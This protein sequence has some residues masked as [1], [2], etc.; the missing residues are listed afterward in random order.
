MKLLVVEDDGELCAQVAATLEQ[1]GFVVD[2]AHDG[3]QGEFLGS[4]ERYAAVVLDLG[5]PGLGGVE[6]LQRWR[7][8]GHNQP[9]LILT[10]RDA[11]GDKVAAF[12]AGA[13][14]YL[15]KPFRLEELVLRLQVLIR[16]AAGHAGG[17][18]RAG[19]LALDTA[20]GVITLNGLALKLTAFESRLLRLLLL[21]KGRTV[22]RT[23]MV[24]QMYDG[25]ADR[26]F[27]SLEVV[28][29]RLRR[30]LGEGRIE[31]V[32]GEGYRLLDQEAA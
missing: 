5:L 6:V 3:T 18:V 8:A 23:D 25:D 13:D 9:V 14:D 30:K 4:T 21:H 1:A 29:G 16:R 24:E 2:R 26:D 31:T 10:A 17:E 27:R 19:P 12:K 32:R 15:T 11:W 20:T 7:S 28:M 22:S